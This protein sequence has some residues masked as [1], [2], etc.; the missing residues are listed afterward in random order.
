MFLQCFGGNS[1]YFTYSK[2]I[3]VY[4]NTRRAGYV[5]KKACSCSVREFG[6]VLYVEGL[7]GVSAPS[8]HIESTDSMIKS[9]ETG[10]ATSSLP[11]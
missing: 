1:V 9:N 4:R 5:A 3:F 6:A 11:S 2:S 8:L 10:Q 7:I